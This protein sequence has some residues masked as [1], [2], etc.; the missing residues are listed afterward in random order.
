VCKAVVR[1]GMPVFEKRTRIPAPP[2]A[3]FAFHERPD[4]LERLMP[5]WEDARIIER[6]GGLEEGA[7]VVLE[8][9]IG[10][11]KQ[12]MV[13]VHTAYLKGRMFQDTMMEGPFARWVHTHRM[14][15]D[16]QGG[17]WLIDHIAYE[18]PFGLIGRIAG[19]WIAR[20]R[21][22]KMFDYRHEITKKAF[23]S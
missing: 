6:T 18:L 3:V 14:E 22:E 23:L 16:G 10:P 11:L 19:G 21:L 4:A 17:T 20:R 9:R 8:A 2:E 7:R 13:A 5:P 1:S 15:P 12:R